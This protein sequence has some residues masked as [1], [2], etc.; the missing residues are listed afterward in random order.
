[1]ENVDFIL[2]NCNGMSINLKNGDTLLPKRRMD[3]Y[4]REEVVGYYCKK[5][6]AKWGEC[7][8]TDYYMREKIVRTVTYEPPIQNLKFLDDETICFTYD[9]SI[10]IWDIKNNFLKHYLNCIY[11]VNLGNLYTKNFYLSKNKKFLFLDCDYLYIFQL[12]TKDR[13]GYSKVELL[14]GCLFE[15]S[16]SYIMLDNGKNIFLAIKNR[17]YLNIYHI[18][19]DFGF[20]KLKTFNSE[21]IINFKF[22]SASFFN[23]RKWKITYFL[24]TYTSGFRKENHI[25]ELNTAYSLLPEKK[26]WI[27]KKTIITKFK[28]CKYQKLFL[29]SDFKQPSEIGFAMLDYDE[30]Q[31]LFFKYNQSKNKM[32]IQ[33]KSLPENIKPEEITDISFSKDHISFTFYFDFEKSFYKLFA[34]EEYKKTITLTQEET[35]KF[36]S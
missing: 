24:K 20:Q 10:Q 30:N 3:V 33:K 35:K 27:F 31:I 17:F 25:F 6:N 18:S 36:Y 8:G 4:K 29:S 28:N 26:H 16:S 15:T 34:E 11:S 1:M 13:R 22:I 9:T 7:S 32:I 14:E 12:D 2:K 23:D 5:C 21:N 19:E